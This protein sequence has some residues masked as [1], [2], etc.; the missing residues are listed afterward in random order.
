[1]ANDEE[2]LWSGCSD[3]ELLNL[4]EQTQA[5]HSAKEYRYGVRRLRPIAG[6]NSG[7][8][9]L[10]VQSVSAR[11]YDFWHQKGQKLSFS[12][13]GFYSL[14]FDVIQIDEA[15]EKLSEYYLTGRLPGVIKL[16]RAKKSRSQTTGLP[17]LVFCGPAKEK[18]YILQIGRLV[19]ITLDHNY[20]K[21]SCSRG[22]PPFI[23]Y[24]LKNKTAF[25]PG[26]PTSYA[27][28]Y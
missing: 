14:F 22:F 20:K 12:S 19:L 1:M 10:Q 18:K 24:R 7:F 6:E 3:S 4:Y 2:D 28:P 9:F 25:Y 5:E 23:Y 16:A 27:L 26:G 8:E 13:V 15:W 21:A 17:I 11:V